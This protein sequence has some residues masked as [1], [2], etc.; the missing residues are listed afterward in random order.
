MLIVNSNK[1]IEN[2]SNTITVYVLGRLDCPKV[3]LCKQIAEAITKNPNFL[4][5]FNFQIEF[6]T[7]FELLREKLLKEDTEFLSLKLLFV[8]S[9]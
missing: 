7:Q 8:E 6:E 4:I 2:E 1:Q 3:T 5:R 9:K